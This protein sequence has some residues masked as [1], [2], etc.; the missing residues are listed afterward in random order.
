MR[1][2]PALLIAAGSLSPVGAFATDGETN[3]EWVKEHAIPFNTQ[4][5][6]NGFED[7]AP[8]EKII[9]HKKEGPGWSHL[10]KWKGYTEQAGSEVPGY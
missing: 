10:I 6:G 8:L 1:L 2:L 9:G 5:A 4:E 7:L 3:V